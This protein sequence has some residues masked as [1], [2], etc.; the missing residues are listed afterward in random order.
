M[1]RATHVP[2]PW[3]LLLATLAALPSV[4]CRRVTIVSFKTDFPQLASSV[5]VDTPANPQKHAIHMNSLSETIGFY[6]LPGDHIQIDTWA[7]SDGTVTLFSTDNYPISDDR[8]QVA[9]GLWHGPSAHCPQLMDGEVTGAPDAGADGT[10]GVGGSTGTGGHVDVGG[11]GGQAGSA[12][13]AGTDAGTGGGAGGSGSGVDAG[14]AVECGDDSHILT[15]A[16][17]SG[18]PTGDDVVPAPTYTSD[19]DTYCADMQ[20]TCPGQYASP[21]SCRRYCAGVAW[22]A[23]AGMNRDDT[24]SCRTFYLMEAANLIPAQR[25]SACAT[26]AAQGA[27]ECGSACA[28]FC[29]AWGALCPQYATDVTTCM[30]SCG[31]AMAPG[32]SEPSCRFKLLEQAVYDRR[33]CDYVKFG[34]CLSCN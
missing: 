27:P 6:D 14:D 1:T 17:P 32:S 5:F 28:N 9:V 18:A 7:C 22:P 4:G 30:D 11:D 25:A 3:L 10:D 16:S 23:G 13:D 15:C 19:C 21:E 20:T 2:L 26:A 24:L 8:V 34:S 33:Y 12:D 29:T 31:R